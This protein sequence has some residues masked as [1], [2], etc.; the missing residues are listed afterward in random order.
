MILEDSFSMSIER[1]ADGSCTILEIRHRWSFGPAV[2]A[3][4]VEFVKYCDSEIVHVYVGDR[5]GGGIGAHTDGR[6][7]GDE[8]RG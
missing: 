1:R 4:G 6:D 7:P 8:D 3:S 5:T 2:T